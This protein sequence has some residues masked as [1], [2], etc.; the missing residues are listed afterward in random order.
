[1][2]VSGSQLTRIGSYFAGVAKKLIILAK[3]ETVITLETFVVVGAMD[4]S[5]ITALS[6][7]SIK[8]TVQSAMDTDGLTVIGSME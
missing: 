3:S 6:S 1:M 7:M 8:T 2:A 4:T 5:G